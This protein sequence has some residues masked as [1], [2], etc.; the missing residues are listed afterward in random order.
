VT[1]APAGVN[2]LEFPFEERPHDFVGL[3]NQFL[4]SQPNAPAVRLRLVGAYAKLGC[5]RLAEE[6][7]QALPAGLKERTRNVLDQLQGLESETALIEGLNSTFQRNFEAAR[8]NNPQLDA[9]PLDDLFKQVADM[10]VVKCAGGSRQYR[11]PGSK[12]WVDGFRDHRK[13]A[14]NMSFPHDVKAAPFP[15]LILSPL[16]H[17]ETLIRAHELTQSGFVGATSAIYVLEPDPR[18]FAATLCLRNLTEQLED[19]RVRLFVGPNCLDEMIQ[20]VEHEPHWS[21]PAHVVTTPIGRARLPAGIDDA[22]VGSVGRINQRTDVLKQNLIE[23]YSG[24]DASYLEKRLRETPLRIMAVT[25]RFTTV[26]KHTLDALLAALEEA[27]H[28]TRVV[29]E[30]DDHFRLG[31]CEVLEECLQFEPDLVLTA[32]STRLGGHPFPENLPLISWMQDRLPRLLD[33]HCGQAVRPLDFVVGMFKLEFTGKYAYPFRQYRSMPLLAD[34]SA[35]ASERISE[36]LID[37]HRCD[38]SYVSHQSKSPEQIRDELLLKMDDSGRKIFLA[39]YDRIAERYA[40]GDAIYFEF[41][42]NGLAGEVEQEMGIAFASTYRQELLWHI[43]HRINNAF[44]RGQA[45]DWV[46]DQGVDLRLYGQGWEDH[47]RLA[48]FARGPLDHGDAGAVYRGSR[49][50]LQILPYGAIHHRML[51][52][53]ASGGFFLIRHHPSDQMHRIE[54]PLS[55]RIA[56]LGIS[57]D[58]ELYGSDDPVLRSLLSEYRQAQKMDTPTPMMKPEELLTVLK[59]AEENDH[60]FRAG[61]V[62]PRLEEVT[63]RTPKDLAVL[64]RKYL[65]DEED[66][67]RM[68]EEQ[69]EAVDRAFSYRRGAEEILD[70]YRDYI[71]QLAGSQA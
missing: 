52:G 66:R 48:R 46:A 11:M 32:D 42:T 38:V 58:E 8:K 35:M 55:R 17:G 13:D 26:L 65:D 9:L 47:P 28:R 10:E 39:L 21:L 41:D 71:D 23:L 18:V 4:K 43:W 54:I 29:I 22:I 60:R 62:L 15:A 19:P 2:L 63:F 1:P 56:E 24:R 53:M 45:L 64:L 70:A 57:R 14:A 34:M 69:R 16:G 12:E 44:Y 30:P 49:V 40:A 51:N 25:S 67:M 20:W 61:H 33:K 37:A 36:E 31:P 50:N 3:A 6:E 59:I 68:I 5:G 7:W 27:G